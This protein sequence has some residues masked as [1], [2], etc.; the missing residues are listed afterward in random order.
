MATDQ[1]QVIDRS[2]DTD[3]GVYVTLAEARGCVK[4]DR[5]TAY[6]IWRGYHAAD[7]DFVPVERVECCEPYEG[8]DDRAAQGLGQFNLSEVEYG[9]S[10][11][12]PAP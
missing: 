8:G 5:L 12:M 4:F 9:P 6:A 10:Y 2:D 11:D 7:D 3:H 1:Y